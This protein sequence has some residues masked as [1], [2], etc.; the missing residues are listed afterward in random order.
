MEV[1]LSLLLKRAKALFPEQKAFFSTTSTR[2]IPFFEKNNVL[3][4]Y[5]ALDDGVMNT[6]FQAWMTESEDRILT[7]LASFYINRKLLKSV[8]FH[9]ESE[10]QLDGLRTLV[11]DSG[12]D[13]DYYT[14]IHDNFDLPYDFYRPASNR[15]RTNIEILQKDGQLIE[16]SKV[17]PI[18]ESLTGTTHGNRRFYFPKSMLQNPEFTKHI[19]NEELL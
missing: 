9:K 10:K 2:L 12:F 6:Y 5:L 1:L 11:A 15:P 18:V 14:G 13:P 16:L 7:D 8:V 3:K 4:D 17:S 19:K